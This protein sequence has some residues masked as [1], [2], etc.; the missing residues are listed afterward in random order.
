MNR[1]K[2]TLEDA[3]AE[4]RD[5]ATGPRS[6]HWSYAPA[7]KA[8][9][10]SHDELL[11]ILGEAT[12][13]LEEKEQKI[14]TMKVEPYGYLRENSGQVQISIGPERPA[15][16]SGGYA[17]PWGAIYA[18]PPPPKVP[19]FGKLTKEIVENL[20]DCGAADDEAIAQYEEFV[21]KVCR[22]AIRY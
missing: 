12:V 18:A 11:A 5:A 10:N 22:A 13:A 2:I 20:V 4:L 15:D 14:E 6:E 9:L 3:K 8:L 1:I 19:D 7:V 21:Y 16:R 17:T